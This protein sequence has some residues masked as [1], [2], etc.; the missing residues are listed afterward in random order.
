[1]SDLPQN[2]RIEETPSGYRTIR[3]P[4][5]CLE[6]SL[7]LLADLAFRLLV[8]LAATQVRCVHL[9]RDTR[10]NRKRK[11]GGCDR[12]Q[13][14]LRYSLLLAYH[15][16]T[17]RH[18][19]SQRNP[20]RPARA[21]VIL[22]ARRIRHRRALVLRSEPRARTWLVAKGLHAPTQAPTAERIHV[23]DTLAEDGRFAFLAPNDVA[24]AARV[25]RER[26]VS[27]AEIPIN[28]ALALADRSVVAVVNDRTGPSR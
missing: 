27:L 13:V 16:S 17:T 10:E 9:A 5:L 11:Q 12:F 7:R 24:S 28:R 1:M 23:G 21:D 15:C 14:I 26:G 25:L 20:R 22:V 2:H 3:P 18:M 19:G 8:R 4:R 6:A